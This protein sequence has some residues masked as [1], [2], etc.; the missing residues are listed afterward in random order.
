MIETAYISEIV[1]DKIRTGVLSATMLI[2]TETGSIQAGPGTQLDGGGLTL[3]LA[4]SYDTPSFTGTYKVSSFDDSTALMFYENED[5]IADG[6]FKGAILRADG[7]SGDK[8]GALVF[9]ATVDGDLEAEAAR[10]E[11]LAVPGGTGQVNLFGNVTINGSLAVSGGL[12]GFTSALGT[13]APNAA[14]VWSH[15]LGV[16]PWNVNVHV[17]SNLATWNPVQHRTSE[18]EIHVTASTIQVRN[19]TNAT[20]FIQVNVMV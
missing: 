10:A 5:V 16:K 15:G 18:F 19:N 4:S 17:S 14:P 6:N 12:Q 9:H 13:I 8:A 11:L 1:A 2:L 7:A 20:W 3:G